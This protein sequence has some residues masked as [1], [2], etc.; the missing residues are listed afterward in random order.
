MRKLDA[1]VIGS[2]PNGLAVALTLARASL[3]ALVV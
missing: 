2:G 3:A 1:V